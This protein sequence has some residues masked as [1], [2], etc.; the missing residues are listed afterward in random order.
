MVMYAYNILY[1]LTFLFKNVGKFFLFAITTTSNTTY[2]AAEMFRQHL[3]NV[4]LWL[5]P[6]PTITLLLV[7][8]YRYYTGMCT[9]EV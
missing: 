7:L 3:R 9:Q 5:K 6:R 8:K 2:K 4:F 1:P